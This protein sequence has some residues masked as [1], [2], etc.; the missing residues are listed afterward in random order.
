MWVSEE[1]TRPMGVYYILGGIVVVLIV[2][3]FFGVG[4]W[5]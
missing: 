2:A 1:G 3:G 4:S 5:P